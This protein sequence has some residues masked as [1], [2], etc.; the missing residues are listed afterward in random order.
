MKGFY[1]LHSFLWFLPYVCAIPQDE[2]L[3]YILQK[4]SS[5]TM[6]CSIFA[7]SALCASSNTVNGEGLNVMEA[8]YFAMLNSS[9]PDSTV[10]NMDENVICVT[11]SSGP[12]IQVT[13]G[14]GVSAGAASAGASITTTFTISGSDAGGICIFPEGYPNHTQVDPV[15]LGQAKQLV[16]TIID[17]TACH[18]CGQIPIR[19][20]QNVTDG[21]GDNGGLLRIDYTTADNCIDKCIGPGSF[22]GV[23]TTAS[24]A[25]ATAT[26]SGAKQ[27]GVSQYL[28]GGV[29]IGLSLF[30]LHL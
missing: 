21:S 27:T 3:D 11:H 6:E 19:Y 18:T 13:A 1:L 25:S 4:R 17:N 24:T 30:V 14:A 5:G 12:T 8:L 23:T 15:T 22:K 28:G 2:A 7:V 20:L 10:Y 9:L 16:D 29:A 26:H